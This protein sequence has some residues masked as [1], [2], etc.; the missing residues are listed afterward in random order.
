MT[1]VT[2]KRIKKGEDGERRCLVTGEIS[3]STQMIRF[4]VAPSG[5]IVAD[6]AETLPGRGLWVTATRAC[7]EKAASGAV[8]A[9]AAR[10]PVKVAPDF[11]NRLED[12]LKHRIAERLG[13][14]RRAGQL[15]QG[16]DNVLKSLDTTHAPTL[17]IEA[18]DGA[19]DGRRKLLQAAHARGRTLVVV[20]CLKTSE[21]SLALGRENVIH[22]AVRPGAMADRLSTDVARLQGLRASEVEGM[23]GDTPAGNERNA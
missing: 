4:V 13:L 6:L 22:A 20:D 8:F 3:P 16:F 10:A 21:L 19:A 12:L 2:A 23:A 1:V 7:L 5:E 17:L 9:K 14:A 15:V 18:A 11:L